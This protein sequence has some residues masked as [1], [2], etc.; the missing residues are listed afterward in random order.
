MA[1]MHMNYSAL[2]ESMEKFRLA[3]NDK[4]WANIEE[5]RGPKNRM[6]HFRIS[7]ADFQHRILRKG[8]G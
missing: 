8:Y 6:Y 2:W 5:K 4:Y 7:K 1:C 3:E